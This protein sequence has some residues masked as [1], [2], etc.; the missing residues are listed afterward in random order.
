[1]SMTYSELKAYLSLHEVNLDWAMLLV[2]EQGAFNGLLKEVF[3]ARPRTHKVAR[4]YSETLATSDN[5]TVVF[6]G[7]RFSPP[8]LS[9]EAA[10]QGGGDAVLRFSLVAGTYRVTGRANGIEYLIEQVQ[11][12][13]GQGYD[14]ELRA[15]LAALRL[16][17]D[18]QGRVQWHWP[19]SYQAHTQLG[20]VAATREK[21]A[22]ALAAYLLPVQEGPGVLHTHT[23][24]LPAQGVLTPRRFYLSIS[25]SEDGKGRYAVNLFGSSAELFDSGIATLSPPFLLPG[26]DPDGSGSYD[27]AVFIAPILGELLRSPGED[28]DPPYREQELA[29]LLSVLGGEP[30]MKVDHWLKPGET[31]N[32]V[33]FGQPRS[34]DVPEPAVLVPVVAPQWALRRIGTATDD[35]AEPHAAL[36]GTGSVSLTAHGLGRGVKWSLSANAPGQL[37]SQGAAAQ[38]LI[39]DD[40]A[41]DYYQVRVTARDSEGRQAFAMIVLTPAGYSVALT[42]A[43]ASIDMAGTASFTAERAVDNAYVVNDVGQVAINDGYRLDYQAPV[44]ADHTQALVVATGFKSDGF[45]IVDLT[46][47]ALNP[48]RWTSLQKFTVECTQSGPSSDRFHDRHFANG[49]QQVEIRITI[50]TSGE[51]VGGDLMYYPLSEAELSTLRLKVKGGS[52]VEF[53]EPGESEIRDGAPQMFATTYLRN[54]YDFMSSSDLAATASAPRNDPEDGTTVRTLYLLAQLDP[55]GGGVGAVEFLATFTDS[56][57]RVHTSSPDSDGQVSITT[58]EPAK[59]TR[60]A[61]N[62]SR[63]RPPGS[64]YPSNCT[65]SADGVVDPFR[66]CLTS[67]DYWQLSYQPRS[68][69]SEVLF[70][71]CTFEAEEPLR[72]AQLSLLRWESELMEETYC[73]Y[74]GYTFRPRLLPGETDNQQWKTLTYDPWLQWLARLRKHSL[75]PVL[76]P[77]QEPAPGHLWLA[78]YRVNNFPFWF[79]N[80]AE[81]T[82]DPHPLKTFTARFGTVDWDTWTSTPRPLRVS[83]IDQFGNR[84][85]LEIGF[86]T[87]TRNTIYVTTRGNFHA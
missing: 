33:A 62:L 36:L 80:E 39:P 14:L 31:E 63:Q 40:L 21:I 25:P 6:Q 79:D 11:F 60:E 47:P 9:V 45:A 34:A 82:S 8:S 12:A 48:P 28:L 19:S 74:T 58:V 81:F 83:L 35:P 66:Q 1:M 59:E 75:S 13:E 16:E 73:T 7:V 43:V 38:Y 50:Q 24:S 72:T 3:A 30:C 77:N 55:A 15:S 32:V 22:A 84:H 49:R 53:L 87:D 51:S 69:V 70:L 2:L 4:E 26:P 5:E 27:A 85:R 56:I 42:P 23:L 76:E 20:T 71:D 86:N 52:E 78:L 10:G 54:R 61:Y 64:E 17:V 57:G 46:P 67:L 18:L 29:A 37:T 41:P 65:V 44:E 68:G